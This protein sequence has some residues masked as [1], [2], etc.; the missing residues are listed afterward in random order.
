MKIELKEK[1][2]ID[3]L[4]YKGL[5][6]IQNKEWFCFGID[7]VI[8][9]N[10][11]KDSKKNSKILDLGTGTGIISILLSK[12]IENSKITAVE[13]QK[14]VAEMAERS[15]KLN[16]LEDSIQII[17]EDIKNLSQKIGQAQFDVV[18]TNPPY[19][20]KKTGIVNTNDIK[21]ISRHET[22]ADLKDFIRIA[23]EQLKERGT[24]YMIDRP[25][26]IADIIENLRK[27]KLEP[28]EIRF[29]HPKKDRAPN[30][31]LVKAVKNAGKFL[32]IDKPLIIYED[33]GTYTQEILNIYNKE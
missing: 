2:R 7:S 9:A 21:T 30:E 28:K 8:L 33:D 17:N 22:T 11:A 29:I 31:V 12:K 26:R 15:V 19:K 4:Q 10:F 25:E 32:K 16:D 14:E 13:L 20:E 5:K 23:S 6:I 1:E 3:D 27:Y 24:F 18:I